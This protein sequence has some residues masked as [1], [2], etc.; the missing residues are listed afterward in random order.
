MW[1]CLR[2]ALLASVMVLTSCAMTDPDL[3]YLGLGDSYTIGE[4][5]VPGE[6]WPVQLAARLRA[7]GV[8]LNEPRVVAQT[9][10]TVSELSAAMDAE[11][12]EPAYDLVTLLIGVNDQYR[13]GEAG[14]YAVELRAMLVRAVSLAGSRAE[15]VI[16]VSIPD[17]GVAAFA[18]EDPR[19]AAAIGSAINAFNAV[20]RDEA[21]R[22]GVAFVDITGVSRAPAHRAQLVADRLHPSA[23]Q[24]R[25]WAERVLPVAR[26]A[27]AAP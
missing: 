23:A 15:R 17:W 25:A 22:A 10:W 24:Y 20:A 8:A 13:R 3:R 6:R 14:A 12:L 19:G 11:A 2:A 26:A 18:A 27:L 9:G 4:G 21:R 7:D 16:L 1:R 5:V